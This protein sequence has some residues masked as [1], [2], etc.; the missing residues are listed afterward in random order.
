MPAGV[1]PA[2][3]P[4][5][6]GPAVAARGRALFFD[7]AR[8]NCGACH[9]VGGRGMAIGPDLTALPV[10]SAGDVLIAA[11]ATRAQHVITAKLNDGE[12]FPAIRSEQAGD[13]VRLYDVTSTPP[14]LRTLQR[15]EIASLTEYPGWRH[16]DFLKSYTRA[17]L[18]EIIAY[19]R[20][21]ATGR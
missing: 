6:N 1:G 2:S 5:F 18:N 13:I 7:A 9:A 8:E 4:Q 19:V 21:A 14:V 20:W 3:L 11:Q 10:K 16:N 17:E 12:Q 15:S